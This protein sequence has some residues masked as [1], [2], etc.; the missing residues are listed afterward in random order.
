MSTS[1]ITIEA[2]IN[3]PVDVV[4]AR[5]TTPSD[6]MQWNH[7][8]DDW[9]C[10]A[11]SNDLRVGGTF[12]YTMAARDGSVSFEFEGTYDDVVQHARIAYTMPDGR[13]VVTTFTSH[14]GGTHVRTDFDPETM[15]SA[16]LQQA[17]WQA[18]LD[19]F[20]RHV[21]GGNG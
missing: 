8:S 15:H 19:N 1:P 2:M 3:A 13:H 7:A 16:E 4:W 21:E 11:A 17:G 20:T 18:I 10:P 14:D 5:W 6:I 9:H 12:V